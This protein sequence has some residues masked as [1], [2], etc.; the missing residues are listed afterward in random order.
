MGFKGI[1]LL[2]LFDPDTTELALCFIE[3]CL[4][5]EADL[6]TPLDLGIADVSSYV[7]LKTKKFLTKSDF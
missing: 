4:F 6:V 1:R 3:D 5:L 7:R 2:L